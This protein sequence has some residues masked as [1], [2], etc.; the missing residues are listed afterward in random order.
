M[1]A[2]REMSRTS[3]FRPDLRFVW[4]D[5]FETVEICQDRVDLVGLEYKFWHVRMP[6]NDAF[7]QCFGEILY[8][9]PLYDIPKWRRLW[10]MALIGHPER[11]TPSALLLKNRF[12]AIDVAGLGAKARGSEVQRG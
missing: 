11:M 8:G 5:A 2:A 9:I 3:P 1:R 4:R 7:G 6:R 10:M 12:S